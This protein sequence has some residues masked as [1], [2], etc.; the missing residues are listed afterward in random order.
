[1]QVKAT[2]VNAAGLTAAGQGI[3][4]NGLPVINQVQT[5]NGNVFGPECKVTISREGKNLSRRQTAQASQAE[6]GVQDIR[7]AR[8]ERALLRLQQD[9][10]QGQ[11]IGEK[12][13]DELDELDQKIKD[14]NSA[15][16][17]DEVITKQNKLL[18]A[19]RK[20]K[21]LQLEQNEKKAK[22]ARQMAEQCSGYQNEID[23]NNRELL[24]LLRTMREAEK[25]EEE[26]EEGKAADGESSDKEGSVSAP[27]GTMNS[28]GDVIQGVA[29]QFMMSAMEREW[30]A[31]D[32]FADRA[33]EGHWMIGHANAV[34]QNVLAETEKLR[35]A[36]EDEAF[37]DEQ[38]A[39]LRRLL[40]EGTPNQKLT[41]EAKKRGWTTG[42]ELNLKEID[43][44]RNQGL[45]N[46]YD[47]KRGKRLHDE[48]N[49]LLSG[50]RQTEKDIMQKAVDADLGMARRSSLDKTSQEL[51]EEV[52]ELID[53]RNDVDRIPQDEE[54]D[55][56]KQLEEEEEEEQA[57]M[58][59]KLLQPKEQD[60][61]AI[62]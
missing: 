53:E 9:A 39:E 55:R 51:E 10:D 28:V 62:V 16:L 32:A 36:Y 61:E 3:Q 49:P 46:L 4:E 42:M 12:Y 59:E 29:V 60:R 58:Q 26:R 31:Q 11:G 37:S 2:T 8:T 22:E 19:L 57:G 44:N 5:Q 27:F 56:E 17:D 34:A 18:E 15:N 41:E 48:K 21:A 50:V 20:E 23:E 35:M 47:A 45:I 40:W 25:A 43:E 54:D 1:M 6:T 7:T 13:R 24:T 38:A 52:K 33:D 14:L 30:D